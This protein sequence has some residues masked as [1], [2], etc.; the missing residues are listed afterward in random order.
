M[1]ESERGQVTGSAA[2]VYEE[3]F[4]PALFGQWAEPMLDAAGVA[5]GDAVLDVG[6]G[7]GVVARAAARR[8]APT[9]E[10]VGLD[11][12]DAMLAVARRVRADLEWR[13]GDVAVAPWLSVAVTT[14]V[15]VPT[16]ESGGVPA[17][18]RV[19]GVN[20]S[21]AGPAADSVRLSPSSGSVNEPAGRVHEVAVREVA[22]WSATAPD[23]ANS[24]AGP[25]RAA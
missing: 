1:N 6:C 18:V 19:P 21:H 23:A 2:E 12:N 10:V 3:F 8:V 20:E 16:A 7:T 15:W 14:T 22:P 11:R 24:R 9:G 4:V 17:K 13:Q 25:R 5:H